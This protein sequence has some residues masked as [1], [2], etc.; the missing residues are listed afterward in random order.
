M[1]TLRRVGLRARPSLVRLDC[2][3][4]LKEKISHASNQEAN[5]NEVD[6]VWYCIASHV[7][8]LICVHRKFVSVNDFHYMDNCGEFGNFEFQYY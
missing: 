3:T 4:L 5:D 7:E 8:L 6:T 1:S 2:A